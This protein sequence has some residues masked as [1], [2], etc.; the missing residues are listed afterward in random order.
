M[1]GAAAPSSPPPL[2]EDLT[3]LSPLSEQR[4]DAQAAWLAEGLGTGTVLDVGCG[5]GELLLR[6]LGR[7]ASATAV[8]VDLEP[9]RLEEARRRAAAR[10][11][12]DRA[13]FVAG[14]AAGDLRLEL[15]AL[16]DALVVSGASQV[17]GPP[18][19]EARPLDYAAALA[20]VRAHVRRGARVLYAEAVWSCPPT[21]AAVAPL[22]GR[23]DEFVTLHELTELAVEHGFAV[24]AFGESSPE[25]W[26]AFESGFS[27]G[28]ARWLAEHGP[29]HPGAADV[30]ARA[31]GQR[32]AYL[33]GYRG[34]L[35]YA[36]L[37]LLAV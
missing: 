33:G 7:A 35:G 29:A 17:W 32:A 34:V 22:S 15:P 8:G 23:D 12:G 9:L 28:A 27:A 2:W 1:T 6:V 21:P 19:E 25:E 11:L 26:D 20:A 4:A 16:V 14:D 24:V 36:H 13:R 10:G 18:V 5:W 3:F 37:Q 30:A 31:A